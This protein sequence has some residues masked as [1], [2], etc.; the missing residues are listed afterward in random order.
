MQDGSAFVLRDLDITF[1]EGQL[2]IVAGS[3][4][5]GKSTLLM[6]LLGETRQLQG[7]TFMPCPV[8]RSLVPV[9]EDGL[10][11]TVAYCSQTPWLLSTSVKENILFGSP[12]DER[13]Y[14]LVIKACALD[15]DLKILEY[16][17]ETLVGEKGTAL[18]GGQ[19]ARISLA[20][21]LYSTA[22]V[23][24]IDDAL[25]AL[26]ATTSEYIYRNYLKGSLVR[27]RTVV[28]VT[29]AVTL[30]LPGA[31][32]VVALDDGKVVAQGRPSEVLAS[33]I[34][35]DEGPI[36]LEDPALHEPAAEQTIEALDEGQ[37]K[38]EAAEL[39]KRL[40]KKAANADEE[41][42]AEGAVGFKSYLFYFSNF[43]PNAL[44]LTLLWTS[45]IALFFAAKGADVTSAA[46]LRK[47][48][49]TYD[50]PA[51]SIP[52]I[53]TSLFV[54][55]AQHA[56]TAVAQ[57]ATMDF[58]DFSSEQ[59]LFQ[60]AEQP[61]KDGLSRDSYLAIYA[62]IALGTVLLEMIKDGFSLGGSVLASRRIYSK[63]MTAIFNA[64]PGFFDKTPVGR[65]MNRIA[66]DMETIDQDTAADCVFF[67]DVLIQSV[68]ILGIVIYAI[69]IFSVV[70]VLVIL[71]YGT[72][73]ALYIV[74]SRDLKRIESVQRSP[75]YSLVGE[76]LN[77]SVAIRAFGDAGRFVRH[78]LR[79]I[80]KT[81]RPFYMLWMAN[82]WLSLRVDI[83]AA[84]ISF[85]V[86]IFLIGTPTIDAGLAGFALSYAIMLVDSVLWVV[87]VYSMCE[88]NM[89]SIERVQEYLTDV[90]PER[91]A[92]TEPPAYWPSQTGNIVI[93]NLSVRYSKEFPRVLHSLS[94]EIQAGHK[95]GIVGRTGSGKSSLTLALFRFLEAEEG[96][97]TIDGIDISTVPLK[98]LRQRLTVIPQQPDLFSGTVRSNLDPFGQRED[99]ELWNALE[100]CKLAT[101]ADVL[102]AS[103]AGSRLPS[104]PPS[105]HEDDAEVGRTVVTS[106]DMPVEQNGRNFSQGQRQLL[107]LARGLLKLQD[108][109]ILILD[110][111]TASLDA[112]S[113]AAIQQTIRQEMSSA[114]ILTVAH[115][116][117]T[118]ADFDRVLVLDRGKIVEYAAPY[119]LL[120]DEKSSF[121]ELAQKSGE[122]D[123]LL[124]MAKRQHEA[125][126]G[127]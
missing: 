31:G 61:K 3:V 14:K 75:I 7:K 24:L 78:S 85:T 109:R 55:P 50:G 40:D 45:V 102:N 42:Y 67:I 117:R 27:G 107:A 33:G 83:F 66:K 17:D 100:R 53:L 12:Y 69:P 123:H 64:K 93:D 30:C 118:I 44:M 127:K 95:V 98:T 82:R 15:P 36:R 112:A 25:S 77:G 68:A 2:S 96:K 71:G 19:K 52:R 114:T 111:S 103:R 1:P 58:S 29:H 108:S 51:E 47:W 101:P 70:S 89:N 21:A 57:N 126:G 56:A 113:D 28:M 20:R 81:N 10:S 62:A 94:L 74:S 4:G 97:V 79:L 35:A 120:T 106:L 110:E 86:A 90:E 73:G 115:R 125:S 39:K 116:L 63:L 88:I 34:F 121:Y 72:I 54:A 38:A 16:Y 18:S 48:A 49:S 13:R 99:A 5:S 26:D 84:L 122:F 43:A 6:S 37:R 23:L 65:I 22:R 91:F 104:R 76:I 8:A 41:A 124:G 11:D 87:R 105:V 59:L 92:G 32:Y 9:E 46:W 60:A 80:D 119:E